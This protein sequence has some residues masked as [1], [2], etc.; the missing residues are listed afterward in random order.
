V[1]KDNPLT[2]PLPS[3]EAN[4]GLV[5]SNIGPLYTLL[6]WWTHPSAARAAASYDYNSHSADQTFNNNNNHGV[7]SNARAA[8]RTHDDD[9]DDDDSEHSLCDRGYPGVVI[10]DD[11]AKKRGMAGSASVSV[12]SGL[13]DA[14]GIP[15]EEQVRSVGSVR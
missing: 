6:R 14:E 9:D 13:D 5:A 7:S 3:L 4:I 1:Q 8:T 15:L 11:G 2:S 12:N 10:D